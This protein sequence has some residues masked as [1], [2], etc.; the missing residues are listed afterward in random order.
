MGWEEDG[1]KKDMGKNKIGLF[2]DEL[3]SIIDKVQKNPWV[4]VLKSKDFK[5]FFEMKR[6]SPLSRELVRSDYETSNMPNPSHES[7]TVRVR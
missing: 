1:W 3:K 6:V 2:V 5:E 7:T 4:S